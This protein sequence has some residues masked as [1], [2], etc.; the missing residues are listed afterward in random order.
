[1][2]ELR[3]SEG[4]LAMFDYLVFFVHENE[5]LESEQ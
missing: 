3:S 5:V 1:M 2:F 4:F